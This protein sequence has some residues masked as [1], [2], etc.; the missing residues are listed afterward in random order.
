MVNRRQNSNGFFNNWLI[1]FLSAIGWMVIIPVYIL[2][3]VFVVSKTVWYFILVIS[4]FI[5]GC[6]QLKKA[7]NLFKERFEI[8]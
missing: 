5:V 2:P 1:V 6:F 4:C 8:S 3:S 7:V